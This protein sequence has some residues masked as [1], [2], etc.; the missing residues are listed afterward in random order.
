MRKKYD[1]EKVRQEFDLV[2]YVSSLA[3]V[4]RRGNEWWC[5]CPL[6]T[7]D[8]ASF[9]IHT[10]GEQW[11]CFVCGGGDSF[12]FV[13][14]YHNLDDQGDDFP[15]VCAIMCGEQY[16]IEPTE[17]KRRDALP[18]TP[19]R[20]PV[21]NNDISF[22]IENDKR[23]ELKKT[24]NYA[25]RL[26]KCRY[27]CAENGKKTFRWYYHDM[28]DINYG[29]GGIENGLYWAL[30]TGPQKPTSGTVFI[31]EG[32]KTADAMALCGFVGV[33]ACDGADLEA[34][35]WSVEYSKELRGFDVVIINDDDDVGKQYADKVA[36]KIQD[37]AKTV[38]RIN[39]TDVSP[40][41]DGIHG[42]DMADIIESLGA[43]VTANNINN[44]LSPTEYVGETV[45]VTETISNDPEINEFLYRAADEMYRKNLK[46]L[47]VSLEEELS[48]LTLNGR[49]FPKRPLVEAIMDILKERK[50][51]VMPTAVIMETPGTKI[52]TLGDDVYDISESGFECIDG[53]I[54]DSESG[55]RI[56]PHLCAYVADII[57]VET[58][59]HRD[60]LSFN[61][62]R[63]PHVIQTRVFAAEDIRSNTKV[64]AATSHYGMDLLSQ[65]AGKFCEF[66]Q[67]M[68]VNQGENLKQIKEINRIGWY[69]D[70]LLPFELDKAN[71]VM[72][73][74]TAD[75][76]IAEAFLS[77]K[78]SKEKSRELL[79]E[80]FD[81]SSI[82]PII[83]G[84]ITS[85]LFMEKIGR[86]G[87]THILNISGVSATGKSKLIDFI[88]SM[89]GDSLSNQ[90]YGGADATVQS[91]QN[92]SAYLRNFALYLDDSMQPSKEDKSTAQQRVYSLVSGIGRQRNNRQG[93][94][95]DYKEWYCNILYT[96]ESPLY[97]ADGEEVKGGVLSR[98]LDVKIEE[99]LEPTDI[100]R[101]LDIARNNHGHFG[102]DFAKVIREFDS[103]DLANWVN[104][105][106]SVFENMGVDRKRG[107]TAAVV[108][109][110]YCIAKEIVGLKHEFPYELVCENMLKSGEISDGARAYDAFVA[111]LNGNIERFRRQTDIQN[112]IWGS[113]DYDYKYKK[114]V[115]IQVAKLKEICEVLSLPR[116]S[117]IQ[118]CVAAGLID[119]SGGKTTQYA[120]INNN[121]NIRVVSFYYEWE[122]H[123][124]MTSKYNENTVY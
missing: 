63:E 65:H 7:E 80:V 74:G 28:G 110:G 98:V 81:Y 43:E 17:R 104:S 10:D 31:I 50:A 124:S 85:S 92:K 40:N 15:Q 62:S 8:T 75:I 95:R 93:E 114:V 19:I 58:G 90:M 12:R 9:H 64:V 113:L 20:K 68:R 77:V 115:N 45:I 69:N 123:Q 87:Q 11:N 122:G 117:M 46:K 109:V 39:V 94:S 66:L 35:K 54:Y 59:W 38:K 119:V 107:Q 23:Y 78:G 42:Y 73:Q 111:W 27:E 33:S 4:K 86:Q 112:V 96:N 30:P 22:V 6:H 102:L 105:E 16:K 103:S 82:A 91:S 100:V 120:T 1:K 37:F 26:I 49:K 52:I 47:S 61:T 108:S 116:N 48:R 34:S 44:L 70:Y 36:F 83:M 25:E 2:R 29:K 24:Y 88:Y 51:A 97:S 84:T 79:N 60:M 55:T 32:E 14:K 89:F 71:I 67:A 72:H 101:W 106:Y 99:S 13:A 118:H 3:E 121:D 41:T 18:K 53:G 56:I 5:K 76:R 21:R 57:D